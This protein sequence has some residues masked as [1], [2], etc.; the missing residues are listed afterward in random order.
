MIIMSD[1]VLAFKSLVTKAVKN[2]TILQLGSSIFAVIYSL[3]GIFISVLAP[4]KAIIGFWLTLTTALF[5]IVIS[6][7]WF[8]SLR[9]L[10]LIQHTLTTENTPKLPPLPADIANTF[11]YSG[12]LTKGLACVIILEITTLLLLYP[13]SWVAVLITGALCLQAPLAFAYLL[14]RFTSIKNPSDSYNY[15]S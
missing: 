12:Y 4:H 10:K 14:N 9:K 13:Q 1:N 5:S 6:T 2:A 8:S 7:I 11:T 3:T 15:P